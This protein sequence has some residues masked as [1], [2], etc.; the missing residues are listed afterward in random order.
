MDEQTAAVRRPAAAQTHDRWVFLHP[1]H[2][3]CTL[4][5]PSYGTCHCGCSR[6]P[7]R[8]AVTYAAGSRFRDRPYVFVPGHHLRVFHPRAGSWSKN[9]VDVEKI[10]PLVF[11]LRER[12]GS[13]RAV[14]DLVG[15]PE[16]TLRGYVYNR[17]RKHV[18]GPT[19]KRIVSAVLAHRRPTD[20]FD[21]WE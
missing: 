15:M 7:K 2:G 20:P 12:H 1:P 5:C 8:S 16:A 10:R 18:P 13:I 3:T 14:A 17:K 21:A 19:A 9:G 4:G 11:W 6:R